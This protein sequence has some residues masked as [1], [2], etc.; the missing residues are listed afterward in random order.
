MATTT[1]SSKALSISDRLTAGFIALFLGAFLIWGVGLA[2]SMVL[3][4]TAHDTR[5]SYGFPCH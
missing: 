5:H 2:H 4:D 1:V 3:H